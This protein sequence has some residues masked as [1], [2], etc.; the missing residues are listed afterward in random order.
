MSSIEIP[1]S[2][3][4]DRP[5]SVEPTNR[6]EEEPSADHH[7]HATY[8]DLP[9][10]LPMLAP[11]AP[12]MAAAGA[13]R[14]DHQPT[15][16]PIDEA[17][18]RKESRLCA[19]PVSTVM[20]LLDEFSING[21]YHTE[22]SLVRAVQE[23]FESIRQS[24][25]LDQEIVRLFSYLDGNCAGQVSLQ[26]VSTALVLLAAGSEADKIS[27]IFSQVDTNHD[28]LL[29]DIELVSFFQLIFDNVLTRSVM[30]VINANGV[31]L[32]SSSQLAI[33]TAF[34][35]MNMC[36]LNHDGFLSLEEFT[37]WFQQPRLAPAV[38]VSPFV[39]LQV[40]HVDVPEG[41]FV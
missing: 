32:S 2:V 6:A 9:V 10:D 25:P 37:K 35:C 34:E 41:D 24:P 31:A 26:S 29:S 3:L 38:P 36:D 14:I 1:V 5:G 18:V 19:I 15:M 11:E 7:I 40:A 12:V 8:L 16:T 22:T 4:L 13:N 23:M 21:K 33:T 28:N 17:T 27:A 20:R 30:G 39:S